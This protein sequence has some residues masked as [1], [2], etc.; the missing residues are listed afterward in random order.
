MNTFLLSTTYFMPCPAHTL[1]LA[2]DAARIASKVELKR[3]VVRPPW[4]ERLSASE[5]VR[6]SGRFASGL[7]IG[8]ALWAVV[9][10]ASAATQFSV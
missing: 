1:R 5:S 6:R 3:P 2:P 8:A 9:F 10:A 4:I 7:L